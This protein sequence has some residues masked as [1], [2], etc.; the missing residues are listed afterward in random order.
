MKQ[1]KYTGVSQ[2]RTGRLLVGALAATLLASGGVA[3]LPSEDAVAATATQLLS[4]TSHATVATKVTDTD[5][6]SG[7]T[8]AVI[9]EARDALVQ[10]AGNLAS[11]IDSPVLVTSSGSTSTSTAAAIKNL[12]VTEVTLISRESTYYTAGYVAELKSAGVAVAAKVNGPSDFAITSG[13]FKVGPAAPEVVLADQADGFATA[14]ATTYAGSRGLPLIAYNSDVTVD[15]MTSLVSSF[16]SALITH[17]GNPS[18]AP[19]ASMS[20]EQVESYH[21][22][23]TTDQLRAAVWSV[24]QAQAAGSNAANISVAPSDVR[25]P[26]ALAALHAKRT[27]GVALPAGATGALQTN[28]RANDV[29]TLWKNAMQRITLVGAN[30]TST[31]LTNV[32]KPSTVSPATHNAF[33]ATGLQRGTAEGSFTLTTTSVSGATKYSAVDLNGAT[34]ANSSSPVL[35][36]SAT[37]PAIRVEASNSTSVLATFEF[38]A[39]SYE[40]TDMR[41]SVA[42]G[43]MGAGRSTLTILGPAK[44]PRLITRVYVDPYKQ[45]ATPSAEIPV[46]I[47]CATTWSDAGLDGTKQYEYSVSA[48]TNVPA[49]ACDT[50]LA[51]QPATADALESSRL[52]LPAT[53]VPAS[54][55]A[56]T[57]LRSKTA[58]GPTATMNT[59]PGTAAATRSDAMLM[60]K[61]VSSSRSM[62]TRALGDDYPDGLVRWQAYI[63]EYQVPFPGFSGDFYR[64]FKAFHGDGRGSD[65][66][67]SARFTQTVRFGFGSDH[68]VKYVNNSSDYEKMG[69]SIEYKCRQ[70]L[71]GN[72][73]ETRRLTAPLSELNG[74]PGLS[75]NVFGAARLRAEATLP[76][77]KIAPP[78]DTDV[79]IYLGPG[80]SRIFGYHDRMPKH[81]AFFGVVQSEWYRVYSSPYI[82]YAQLPCLYSSPSKP[83]PG[84]GVYFNAQI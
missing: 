17:V 33:R 38:R 56:S 7:A 14:L 44:I 6:P 3:F 28:S 70:L 59:R 34:I 19:T 75:T 51:A 1:A 15:Q 29:I 24:S 20:E 5:F 50:S 18:V 63:P 74:Y 45:Y 82:G 42:L 26:L 49:N 64:P 21:Q 36:F 35:S 4:G 12:G 8:R 11:R 60:S 54:S 69:V 13:V 10:A 47:T 31:D 48:L 30:V 39:N 71:L 83:K 52:I 55:A 84:C 81:E 9:V 72:C 25:G 23:D 58:V 65:P 68:S 53:K 66:N 27:G 41:D 2:A 37:I 79:N 73:E 57:T 43:S 62:S 16:G 78:I 67:G 46:A 61:T 40:T 77:V 80:V 32:A 22:E 76:L